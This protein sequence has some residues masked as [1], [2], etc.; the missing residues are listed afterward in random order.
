MADPERKIQDLLDR[1]V[2]ESEKKGLI[3]HNKKMES[4]V[5][6]VKKR[7]AYGLQHQRQA[8]AQV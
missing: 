2:K 8:C 4:I 1:A 3:I 6:S 7:P 5:V